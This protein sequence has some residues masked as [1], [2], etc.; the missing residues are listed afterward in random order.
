MCTCDGTSPN[1]RPDG[2]ASRTSGRSAIRAPLLFLL[3]LVLLRAA[4]LVAALDP[5]QER[6]ISTLAEAEAVADVVAGTE[7]TSGP[8]RPLYDV[9]ELYCATAAAA[10]RMNLDVPLSLYRFMPYG[11]GSLLVA[12][13]AVPLYAIAGPDYLVFK[14]LALL[15]TVLGGLF[16]FLVVRIWLGDRAA[17]WFGLLYIFAPTVLVRTALIAKGDHPEAMVILGAVC[18]LAS[19]AA[20]ARGMPSGWRWAAGAGLLAGLGVWVTY[21]TLPGLVGFGIVALLISRRR[22]PR[23]WI[24]FAMGL[25]LGLIPWATWI[26]TIPDGLAVYGSRLGT[27]QG[28]G[29]ALARIRLLGERGLLSGYD[30]PG[31][32]LRRATGYLW[33][34]FVILGWIA[35]LRKVR[36]SVPR[37]VLGA[38]AVTLGAFCLAAPDPSSRY[39]IPAYPLFLIAVVW[40]AAGP[41]SACSVRRRLGGALVLGVIVAVGLVSQVHAVLDSRFPARGIPLRGTDWSLLGEVVG[42]KIRP[43]VISALPSEV[44]SHFWVGFGR[45]VFAS[46]EQDSWPAAAALAGSDHAARV[47]EG[48]GIGWLESLRF[49]QTPQYL[50]TLDDPPRSWVRAGLV[51]HAAV[52]FVPV[53]LGIEARRVREFIESFAE[54]DRPEM[55]RALAKTLATLVTHGVAAEKWTR[56]VTRATVGEADMAYG[57]GW[58]LFRCVQ[59]SASPGAAIDERLRFWKPPVGS[60]PET[61]AEAARRGGVPRD[62]WEGIA[63]AYQWDLQVRSPEWILGGSNGPHALAMEL[64]H[65]CEPLADS[66]AAI[67]YRAAGCAAARALRAP[68]PLKRS[69]REWQWRGVIPT[70]L[71]E[72]FITGL[73]SCGA[74]RDTSAA[75]GPGELPRPSE[76]H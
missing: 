51:R 72:A 32:V 63:A 41:R 37:L 24:S 49:E 44:Q 52:F 36:H 17:R 35:L 10:I 40:L 71:H 64:Q 26:L 70:R 67:F 27:P 29:E 2:C 39:L 59:R 46:L 6:T 38:T 1:E 45:R 66:T 19:R 13:L 30:L 20:R 74:A 76:R 48:T 43:E 25:V 55:R 58:A 50:R 73:G 21:S 60:W 69:E 4:F 65:L 15:V 54:E 14:I 9:E 16:W 3:T 33:L 53:S 23:L 62:F 61:F 34:G 5:S 42:M 47:W 56:A 75:P 22:P 57:A 7:W 68:G 8:E 12:L 28:V 11:G 18:Y 31:S